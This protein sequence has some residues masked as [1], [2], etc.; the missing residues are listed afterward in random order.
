[1]SSTYRP[2][3]DSSHSKQPILPRES[4]TDGDGNG[5]AKNG[6]K[7]VSADRIG[8][9]RET[10]ELT[11]LHALKSEGLPRD[12]EKTEIRN[13][14][15]VAVASAIPNPPSTSAYSPPSNDPAYGLVGQSLDHY[16]IESLVGVGGMGAVFRG[17]DLRLDRV[18]AIKVVPM[19]HRKADA[20]RRFRME[21]QSAAKLD[22]PNI[23]RVYYVGETERWSYIVFEF[24]EGTNLRQLVIEHGLLT[25]DD[26]THF[27]CQVAEALQHAHERGVVH[28]DIKPS[29]ILIGTDGRAKIVDM[30]LARTTELDRSTGDLTASGVTLGTF[31]Y[32]S[33][34]Q[35][36]DPR[37][38]DV[39][40]DIYS[41][42]CTLYFLL[43]GQPPFPE[44]TALQKLLMHGTKMPEDPRYFRNDLSDPLIAILRKMMAK[45]PRDRYQ[46]PLDLVN[47]LRML[48][49]IDSLNWG[50][51]GQGDAITFSGTKKP[52]WETALPSVACLILI[53][54]VTMWLYNASQLNAVFPIPRVEWNELATVDSTPSDSESNTVQVSEAVPHTPVSKEETAIAGNRTMQEA[55]DSNSS[56]RGPLPEGRAVSVAR[57]LVLSPDGSIPAALLDQPHEWVSTWEEAVSKLNA[58][59]RLDRIVLQ[60]AHLVIQRPIE[61][62][63]TKDRSGVTI[64]SAAGMRCGVT[65]DESSWK[66]MA[67]DAT[68]WLPLDGIAC[69]FRGLDLEWNTTLEDGRPQSIF[70]VTGS[71]GAAMENCTVTIRHGG[72]SPLPALAQIGKRGQDSSNPS[73][74]TSRFS[75][76]DTS[77]RGQMDWLRISNMEKA[78]IEVRNCWTA[79]AG[80]MVLASGSKALNRSPRIRLE[81]DRSTFITLAPWTRIRMTSANPYPVAIVRVA[82]ESIFSGC[83][84]L[85]EWDASNCNEWNF[86][87]QAKKIE[88]L[89]RWI[90]LRGLDNAYDVPSIVKLVQVL[91]SMSS[92]DVPIDSDSNLLKNERGM[93]LQ[94]A[95]L[96]APRIEAAK[97]HLQT[98][99][100]F[101]WNHGGF[102]PG[103]KVNSLP[104]FPNSLGQ[105]LGNAP[106]SGISSGIVKL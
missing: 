50:Q 4:P 106:S 38:A 51:S 17:R 7:T 70:E 39:R 79:I 85:I 16:R 83:N 71:G 23:A 32:I 99:K 47:D 35:A 68:A 58:N 65:L 54:M 34:E 33:P 105:T 10:V 100:A 37:V 6:E 42:G 31:D 29:N 103:S 102:Q 45:K 30:G 95:W 76:Q 27:T 92:E 104:P 96:A 59:D 64:E 5:Q 87:A 1:M 21:A 25:V 26:A 2:N 89:G 53:S 93:E 48:A 11:E 9:G 8:E 19:A 73:S 55:V 75:A 62:R 43:S 41:L 88:D 24:I 84:T 52:W 81:I 74:N 97:L 78:E 40:S 20:M 36:H 44:G 15:I 94:S 77:I 56:S 14:N 80:S 60:T 28:R 67:L 86:A 98:P 101:E 90:D 72:S 69:T 82:N 63:R 49:V 22:H 3:S 18:V 61:L 91:M 57:T 66:V 13:D 46:E 12:L